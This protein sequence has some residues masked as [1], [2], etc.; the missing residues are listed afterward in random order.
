MRKGVQPFGDQEFGL[1]TQAFITVRKRTQFSLCAYCFLP[2]HWHAI[3]LPEE[4]ASI[5]DIA[6]RIK[7]AAYRRISKARECPQPIWQN[8]FYDHII[9]TRTEFDQTVEYIHQNP[10]EKGLV[11]IQADWMWSSAAWYANQ[12]GPLEIDDVHLPLN[13]EDKI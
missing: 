13:P 7:I 9:R 11:K 6:M 2:D 1:L 10:V 5:S 8:R 12:T 4:R 3:L